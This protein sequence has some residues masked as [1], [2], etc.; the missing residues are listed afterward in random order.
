MCHRFFT[1]CLVY[2]SLQF[3]LA[4]TLAGE[5]RQSE[6]VPWSPQPQCKLNPAKP[7]G[8]H[9]D[10]YAALQSKSIAHRVTQ[11]INNNLAERRNVHYTDGMTN[12][13]P[14][15]GAVDISV[16]CLSESQ[17]K[18]LLTQLANLGFAGW[19]RKDGR[20]GWTGPPHIHAVWA[21]CRLKPILQQQ[22]EAWLSGRNGLGSGE[23]YQFWRPSLALIEKVRLSYR[24]SN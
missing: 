21:A 14:Y 7:A 20:D 4:S 5:P 3:C 16:R 19:Y 9:P 12:G 13:K 15:T 8:L 10:A 6:K 18:A 22:V 11:G 24:S 1:V 2:V 17:I 23:P